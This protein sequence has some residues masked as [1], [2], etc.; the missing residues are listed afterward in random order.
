ME[1]SGQLHAPA[2]LPPGKEPLV[3]IGQE[4]GWAPEPVWMRWWRE[5]SQPLPGLKPPIIQSIAQCYATELSQLLLSLWYFSNKHI[6]GV[7]TTKKIIYHAWNKH[8]YIHTYIHLLTNQHTS[9][10]KYHLSI[11]TGSFWRGELPLIHG[12]DILDWV[13]WSLQYN[14]QLLNLHSNLFLLW[15]S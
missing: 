7:H 4:A 9:N 5:I 3:P 1:V 10:E 12:S 8:T 6:Q 11:K 15:K 14:P 2:A 13:F